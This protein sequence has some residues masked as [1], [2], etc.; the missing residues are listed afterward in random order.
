MVLGAG[1]Y[2]YFVFNFKTIIGHATRINARQGVIVGVIGILILAETMP[3]PRCRYSDP[4]CGDILYVGYAFYNGL[5]QGQSLC[6]SLKVHRLQ[7][8]LYDER[9]YRYSDRCLLHVYRTVYPVRRFP[10]ATGISE[11]FIQLANSPSR[12][13]H[14]RDRQR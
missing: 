6:G 3:P 13:F 11:F 8:V 1:A 5:G 4:L 14:R 12:R 9:C 7:P 2:F 10:E